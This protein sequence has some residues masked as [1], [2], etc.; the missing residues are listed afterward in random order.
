[1]VGLCLSIGRITNTVRVVTI[2]IPKPLGMAFFFPS[3]C[4]GHGR[5]ET[6]H[7]R[8]A[9]EIKSASLGPSPFTVLADQPF[10]A[11]PYLSQYLTKYFY[12]H[13]LSKSKM[14]DKTDDDCAIMLSFPNLRV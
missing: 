14:S 4:H 6:K 3:S 1:M 7:A 10:P 9:P 13:R 5:S 11:L 8:R 2:G 12:I